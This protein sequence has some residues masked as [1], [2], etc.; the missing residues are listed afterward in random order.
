MKPNGNKKKLTITMDDETIQT[1]KNLVEKKHTSIS[2]WI[3]DKVWEASATEQ[4][5]DI[6]GMFGS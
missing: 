6:T 3:T 1:L 2:Q 4:A 5:K